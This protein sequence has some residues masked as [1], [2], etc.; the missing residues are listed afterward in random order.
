M[1]WLI[2]F[3]VPEID[4]KFILFDAHGKKILTILYILVHSWIFDL[5]F[6]SAAMGRRGM[7]GGECYGY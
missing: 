6:W 3:L 1:I 7:C 4:Q 2:E 5:E